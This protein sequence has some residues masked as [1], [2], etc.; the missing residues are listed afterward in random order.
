MK[1]KTKNK[2][3]FENETT[4]RRERTGRNRRGIVCWQIDACNGRLGAKLTK[5]IKKKM[6]RKI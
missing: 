2:M 3:E 1:Y 6:N 5:N 4:K